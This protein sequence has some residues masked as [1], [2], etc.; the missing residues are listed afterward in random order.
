M[1]AL[2]VLFRWIHVVAGIMWI[3]HLYFFNFV[4]G[5]LQ[6]TLDGPTK[7]TVNPELLPRA[8]YWFRWGA[9]WTWVTGVL[10]LLLVFYHGRAARSGDE[11]FTDGSWVMI[12][13][14][15][16]AVFVYDALLKSAL[17]EEPHGGLRRRLRAARGR[18]LL[19][20]QR[21]RL[22]L[23]RHA[24]PHRRALRHDH[25]VQRLVRIWPAQQKIIRAMKDGTAAGRRA[26][27]ARGAALAAQHLPVGAARVDDDQPA[28]DLLRRRQLGHPE[29]LWWIVWLAII[30]V[31]WHIVFQLYKIA[32]KVQGF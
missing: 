4:N 27:R 26:R 8:L 13:V 21:R 32:G 7:K 1:Q 11:G 17:G 14:T 15:F 30:L 3:G 23:P 25:G 20:R 18:R 12:V 19:L 31:G 6:G 10:L 16:L 9:A 28:H 22:R 2:D 29:R 5:P 24:D